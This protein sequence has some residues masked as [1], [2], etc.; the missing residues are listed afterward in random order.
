MNYVNSV[1]TEIHSTDHR[2]ILIILVTY[3]VY[4]LGTTIKFDRSDSRIVLH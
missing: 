4:Q 2:T 1:L 3:T